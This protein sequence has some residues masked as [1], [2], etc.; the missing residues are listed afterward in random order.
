MQQ[1]VGRN[2]M[3]KEKNGSFFELAVAKIRDISFV[4]YER[5]DF[6]KLREIGRKIKKRWCMA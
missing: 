2:E 5:R 6:G 4:Y 3:V 1:R